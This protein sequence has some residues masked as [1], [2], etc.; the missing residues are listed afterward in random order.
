MQAA[1]KS[2]GQKPGACSISHMQETPMT[3][4]SSNTVCLNAVTGFCQLSSMKLPKLEQIEQENKLTFDLSEYLSDV[5]IAE[6]ESK[7]LH[8]KRG[9]DVD[10][11]QPFEWPKPLLALVGEA[12]LS[13]LPPEEKALAALGYALPTPNDIKG[14]DAASQ[15]R[16]AKV[17]K[18]RNEAAAHSRQVYTAM[19]CS[20]ARKRG[21]DLSK[22]QLCTAKAVRLVAEK[23]GCRMLAEQNCNRAVSHVAGT[24][25]AERRPIIDEMY[26]ILRAGTPINGSPTNYLSLMHACQL[27]PRFKQLYD[28]LG[29]KTERS[30]WKALRDAHPELFMGLIRTKKSRNASEAQVRDA[31]HL[32][33]ASRHHGNRRLQRCTILWASRPGCLLAAACAAHATHRL[34]I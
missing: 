7:F 33:T 30:V 34:H 13:K 17:R 12:Y 25:A 4:A 21:R 15:A 16:R 3:K 23:Y 8:L 28:Q 6:V 19:Q 1:G 32:C 29:L 10:D 2:N 31:H 9:R 11:E 24:K 20:L 27:S 14:E 18:Q 5:D 22:E 26:T